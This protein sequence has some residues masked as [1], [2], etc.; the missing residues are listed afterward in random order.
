M[1]CKNFG[2]GVYQHGVSYYRIRSELHKVFLQ[3]HIIVGMSNSTLRTFEFSSPL[4]ALLL[5]V[6][7]AL[8]DGFWVAIS[9]AHV[10]NHALTSDSK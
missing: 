6:P 9:V 5:L 10:S 8:S 2:V 1:N 7:T 3:L 4:A